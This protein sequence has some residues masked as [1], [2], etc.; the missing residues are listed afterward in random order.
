MLFFMSQVS[1][2]DAQALAEKM[3]VQYVETSAKTRNNVDKVRTINITHI[4]YIIWRPHEHYISLN[5]LPRPI[6][7][8]TALCFRTVQ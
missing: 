7:Y 4:G 2:N 6:N 5:R 8:P 3:G 1:L